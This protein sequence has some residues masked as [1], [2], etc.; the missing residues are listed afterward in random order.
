MTTINHTLIFT[1][2][3]SLV[4]NV[5]FLYFCFSFRKDMEKFRERY[6]EALFDF[7]RKMSEIE[8]VAEEIV[9]LNKQAEEKA[10][11]LG[12]LKKTHVGEEE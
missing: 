4:L 2:S 3:I 1:A 8:K 12:F 7:E 10:S 9:V 11:Y 5:V 6:H